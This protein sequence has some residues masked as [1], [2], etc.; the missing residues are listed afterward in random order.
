MTAIISSR[1][2]Y[3]DLLIVSEQPKEKLQIHFVARDS[4][5][6]SVQVNGSKEKVQRKE[7]L[8][9][10]VN[11]GLEGILRILAYNSKYE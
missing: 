4:R 1:F 2:V 10:H 7:E 6:H 9:L 8:A 5:G 3:H 11:T